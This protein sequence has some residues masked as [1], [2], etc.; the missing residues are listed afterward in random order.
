MAAFYEKWGLAR[1]LAPLAFVCAALLHLPG[2]CRGQ[3]PDLT[4]I[5]GQ[6]RINWNAG[7]IRAKGVF[8]W[9]GR[10][11]KDPKSLRPALCEAKEDAVRNLFKTLW[12]IHIDSD[13]VI[14]DA[15]SEDVGMLNRMIGFIKALP[16]SGYK[17]GH[18]GFLEVEIQMDMRG[19]FAQLALPPDIRKLESIK[20]L[21]SGKKR[22]LKPASNGKE[23][24]P[25]V[26][27][28]LVVDAKGIGVLPSMSPRILDRGGKEIYGAAF[29]SREFAVQNG[30]SGYMTDL[31]AAQKS[32]RV[33][34]NPLVARG[35]MSAGPGRS[36]IVISDL[37]ASK[38]RGSSEH[39][40]FLKKCGVIIVTD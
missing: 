5:T 19:E 16:V 39:L 4:Q 2:I 18:D 31:K 37:D 36:D 17:W 13:V 26:F 24:S 34:K 14:S 30:M 9:K 10:N 20:P 23:I 35:L 32:P 28:G 22:E 11:T 6:S 27:T 40:V 38:L 8:H 21:I 1:R 12:D 15:V 3:S 29:V 25:D 7:F 33:G